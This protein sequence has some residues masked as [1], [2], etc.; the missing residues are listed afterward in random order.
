[1]YARLSVERVD[2]NNSK[3]EGEQRALQNDF[4]PEIALMKLNVAHS[5]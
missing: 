5:S 4:E 1:M 2:N 3:Q